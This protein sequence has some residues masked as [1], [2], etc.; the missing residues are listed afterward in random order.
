MP[1][2]LCLG[3]TVGRRSQSLCIMSHSL[4]ALRGSPEATPSARRHLQA[5]TAFC[6]ASLASENHLGAVSYLFYEMTF[7]ATPEP[8]GFPRRFRPQTPLPAS[9]PTTNLAKREICSAGAGTALT[10]VLGRILPELHT[11]LATDLL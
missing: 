5:T 2:S 11:A 7:A 1:A 3:F 10:K 9:A 8:D 6:F 4:F